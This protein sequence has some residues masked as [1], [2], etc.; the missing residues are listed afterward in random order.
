MTEIVDQSK[1]LNGSK[2][3]VIVPLS[4]N[5]ARVPTSRA[6]ERAK[7]LEDTR[8]LPTSSSVERVSS[9][10]FS[11]FAYVVGTRQFPFNGTL[12]QKVAILVTDPTSYYTNTSPETTAPSEVSAIPNLCTVV[13]PVSKPASFDLTRKEWMEKGVSLPFPETR[14]E[15]VGPFIQDCKMMSTSAP[16]PELHSKQLVS[17]SAFAYLPPV[18][19]EK[20]EYTESPTGIGMSYR[21]HSIKKISGSNSPHLMRLFVENPL[22][23]M[24]PIPSYDVVKKLDTD[25]K[26]IGKEGKVVMVGSMIITLPCLCGEMSMEA[27]ILEMEKGTLGKIAFLDEGGKSPF[28]HKKKDNTIIMKASL[29]VTLTQW[30]GNKQWRDIVTMVLW[31]EGLCLY[32]CTDPGPWGN[33]LGLAMMSQTPG[34]FP[35]FVN[36]TESDAQTR[37]KSDD[38]IQSTMALN[39]QQPIMDVPG[40]IATIYGVPVSR[41]WAAT[42]C[43]LEQRRGASVATPHPF[44]TVVEPTTYQSN[45]YNKQDNPVMLV[46]NEL[47]PSARVK[48]FEKKDDNEWLFFAVVGNKLMFDSDKEVLQQLRVLQ[49]DPSYRGPLGEMLTYPDWMCSN[50][51]K[52][53][54]STY[55]TTSPPESVVPPT[56]P[57]MANNT[58]KFATGGALYVYAINTKRYND[59]VSKEVEK[60]KIQNRVPQQ[61]QLLIESSKRT[62]DE[63]KLDDVKNEDDDNDDDGDVNAPTKFGRFE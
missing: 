37:A 7:M 36:H 45:F 59:A 34:F 58:S 5:V 63:A 2:P 41:H 19:N 40:S 35:G 3:L 42:M 15:F 14:H 4:N 54:V 24:M 16:L 50:A 47:H 13:L 31:A 39:A 26:N 56:H 9:V 1:N 28:T 52:W 10:T 62:A 8:S 12:Y 55:G 21:I 48:L 17:I 38:S 30:D 6:L 53:K 27:N 43:L 49:Q 57:V 29:V 32:G 33:G 22:M 23:C 11:T 25:L 20:G 46:L 18:K 44:F 60:I 51:N 61:P